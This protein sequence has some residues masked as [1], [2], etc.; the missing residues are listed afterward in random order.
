MSKRNSVCIG[1]GQS[2][3]H[4]SQAISEGGG[5]KFDRGP[6]GEDQNIIRP[7][8]HPG[9]TDDFTTA[10]LGPIADDGAAQPPADQNAVAGEGRARETIDHGEVLAFES[11]TRPENRRDFPFVSNADPSPGRL[12]AARRNPPTPKG[13]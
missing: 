6:L 11:S 3:E 8:L 5:G 2:F 12:C 4:D 10:S 7:V 1:L 13:S 9:L